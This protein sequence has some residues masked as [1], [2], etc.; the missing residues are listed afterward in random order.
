MEDDFKIAEDNL[1]EKQK[2]LSGLF[3]YWQSV[4]IE[5]E[6]GLADGTLVNCEINGFCDFEFCQSFCM[7]KGCKRLNKCWDNGRAKK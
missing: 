1:E 2:K 7:G 5:Q 6:K 3:G 4:R